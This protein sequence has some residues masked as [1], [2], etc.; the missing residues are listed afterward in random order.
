V[1]PWLPELLL[2]EDLAPHSA[3]M[4]MAIDEA[5][6]GVIQQPVLRFYRWERAA[7]SFGYF[8][9]WEPVSKQYP[10]RDPV[11]RWTGG[12]I[13][14]HGADLTYSLLIPTGIDA[15]PPR[16]SYRLIHGALC[17]ALTEA[18]LA[19]EP[20]SSSAGKRSHACFENP[21]M[22]DVLVNGRKVAGAAQRRTRLGLLH[23]GSIQTLELH[24]DFPNRFASHLSPSV[25]AQSFDI[26][27]AAEKL[28]AEKYRTRNWL[29]RSSTK[30]RAT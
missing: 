17:Q 23:Q 13:V 20:A 19:A 7:V 25:R 8:E 21:V 9:P 22:H 5:L 12:G 6:L 1:C 14:L 24:S 15:G 29:E 28:A 27:I 4:N 2:F 10:S 18:G 30:P 26:T 16:E 11:R 3:A